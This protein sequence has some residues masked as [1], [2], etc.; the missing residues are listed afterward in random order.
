M[1]LEAQGNLADLERA[2]QCQEQASQALMIA[3][4]SLRQVINETVWE[5]LHAETIAPIL[6]AMERH[7]NV[8]LNVST[9]DAQRFR[10]VRCSVVGGILV[11]RAL[12][13]F[14]CQ[15]GLPEKE[16]TRA[17]LRLLPKDGLPKDGLPNYEGFEIVLWL[18][19]HSKAL[20]PNDSGG[21]GPVLLPA[22]GGK[23]DPRY[24]QEGQIF[25]YRLEFPREMLEEFT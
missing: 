5:P 25:G 23:V 12:A 21:I 2:R 15:I 9:E 8:I 7:F 11:G 13:E 20:R 17:D 22:L 4:D 14:C 16:A 6:E 24:N 10:A 19:S 1:W 3:I 18:N